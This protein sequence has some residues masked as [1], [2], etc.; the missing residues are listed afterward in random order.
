VPRQIII[1]STPQE[2]R[3]ATMENARLLEIQIERVRERSLAGSICKG[4]VLR[5][6]PGM[7][8]AFV[9]VGLEKAAFLPGADFFPLSA[10]EYA[11]SPAVD[12][13]EPPPGDAP[14][15]SNDP[16]AP[17][18]RRQRVLPPIEE[19][20]QKGQDV[21]VQISKEPIG[22][23]GARVTSN[24]S[25]PGR[26]LVFL[27]YS[28]QV[29]VSRRIASDEERQRLREAVEAV[30]GDTGGI[31]IRTA[32]EGVSKK[33]IQSDLRLLRRQWQHLSK[34][35]ESLPAP[36]ILH[37]EL[38][39]VLR[40]MR[41]LSAPDV[42]RVVVDNRRDYQRILDFIDE[43]MPRWRPRVELYELAEPIFERYGIE[44]QI[45][46]ALERKVWLK[47]GGYIVIDHTEALT[48]ID[49]NTGRFVGKT[50]QR[51]TALRTNLEAARVL[52]DQLRLRNIGGLI[53]IDFIDMEQ[54]EDRKAVLAALNEALKGD[55]ARATILGLSELGLVEMTRQRTRESLTQRLCEPCPTCG[56]RGHVKA[57]ATTAYEILRRIRREATMNG[58]VQRIE[59]TLHPTV[60]AFLAQHEPAALREIER[61]VGVPVAVRHG[62]SGT[63][64]DYVV[65]AVLAQNAAQ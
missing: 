56:E 43:V 37:Q 22:T 27:P 6:L 33:E 53:I 28:G 10:D 65:L 7:Q 18:P 31:I 19:R 11:D 39:V 32:C 23:K 29:G 20:L 52:V 25:L 15:E 16:G 34:K 36:A 57:V 38:D 4:R 3:V 54:A 46:K 44:A 42:T 55:K 60:A 24:I 41:D 50:D 9:D 47:S 40:T 61:E 8:A 17:P 63:P 62:D 35:A 1:N 12:A 30:A 51:E 13:H 64:A 59:V 58:A 48:A 26:Y 2:A 14:A 5:V 21:I 49:V 45:N